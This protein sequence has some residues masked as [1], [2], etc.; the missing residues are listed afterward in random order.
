MIVKKN[1]NVII[2]SGKDKG[3][4]GKI[5]KSI[6]AKGAVIVEGV[7]LLKKRQRAKKAGQKGQT[8]SV[9]MPIKASAVML[10]CS[11]C[12]KGVRAG[13]NKIADKKVRVCKKC[14]KEI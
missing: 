8:V 5:L 12:A 9:A 10:F 6:P 14:N 4:K 3:K 11:S 13:F 1:D 7:N 2:S